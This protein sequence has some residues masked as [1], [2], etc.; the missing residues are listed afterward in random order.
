VFTFYVFS[1]FPPQLAAFV[2]RVN[3]RVATAYRTSIVGAQHQA[4]VALALFCLIFYVPFPY[5]SVPTLLSFLE[6]LHLSGLAVPAI[7]TYFSSIKARFRVASLPLQPFSSS[8]LALAFKFSSFS[9]P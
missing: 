6:F 9:L 2:G 3:R 4:T 8:S 7:K 5:I 1:D